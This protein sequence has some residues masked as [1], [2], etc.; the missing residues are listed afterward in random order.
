MGR[1]GTEGS[2]FENHR[3]SYTE[4]FSKKAAKTSAK[5]IAKPLCKSFFNKFQKELVEMFCKKG[6]P[7]NFTNFIREYLW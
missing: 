6:V 5:F 7:K 1:Y 2:M 4:I 3:Y